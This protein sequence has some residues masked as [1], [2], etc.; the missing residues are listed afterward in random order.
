MPI[1][2]ENKHLYPKNWDDIREKI[3]ARA[4]NKCELCGL[5]NHKLGFRDKTGKFFKLTKDEK[6]GYLDGDH[7]HVLDEYGDEY[8][9][10][11]VI[12][13]VAHLNHDPTDNKPKNLKALCQK[14]H[15]SHDAK[16]RAINRKKRVS[17]KS[18]QKTLWGE[19]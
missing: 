1:R 18:G 8:K 3:L 13:T 14:C 2:P 4:N 6:K 11:K 5:E 15:N 10:F 7:D 12:L 19:S 16:T 9:I 17:E